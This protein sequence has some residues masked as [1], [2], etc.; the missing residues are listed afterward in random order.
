LDKSG[1][2]AVSRK[3]KV[4]SGNLPDHQEH[5]KLPLDRGTWNVAVGQRR[6]KHYGGGK[7]L[8]GANGWTG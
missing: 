3:A 2:R 5:L 1:F 4:K 8:I 7:N 6:A